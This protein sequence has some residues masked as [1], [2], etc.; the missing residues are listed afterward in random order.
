MKWLLTYFKFSK[1]EQNGFFIILVITVLFFVVY[2]LIK[3]NVREPIPSQAKAF[4]QSFHDSVDVAGLPDLQQGSDVTYV[5]KKDN[6][7]HIQLTA[8]SDDARLF[9][10]DPNNLPVEEWH[11][12]GLTNKQ[13]GVIKNYEK[14]GGSFKNKSD[15]KKIYSINEKLYKRLEPYIQIKIGPEETTVTHYKPS[16]I[17]G[18]FESNK[19]ELI[20]INVCDTTELISLK[21]IGTVLSKRILKYKEVLGGFYRIEQLKEVYGVTAETYDVIKDY[22]VVSNLD[23]I[24]KININHADANSLAKHPYLSPKDAKLI[25]NYRDQHGSYANIEDLAKIGTLSDLAIA[26]IAPYLIFENDSR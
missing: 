14:K 25:V 20:D 24:K 7:K 23:G 16:L 13:I 10:F 18:K 9:Y 21:G 19:A 6:K 17:Y 8:D 11:K 15:L 26:K 22:I 2:T 4:E 1:T 3:Q 5:D 12:L